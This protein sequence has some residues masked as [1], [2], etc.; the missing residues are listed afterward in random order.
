MAVEDARGLSGCRWRF[1]LRMVYKEIVGMVIPAIE[2]SV[3]NKTSVPLYPVPSSTLC[4]NLLVSYRNTDQQSSLL[5]D[6]SQTPRL[7]DFCKLDERTI[8]EFWIR[9]T[10]DRS[11]RTCFGNNGCSNTLSTS[12]RPNTIR[13]RET[14]YVM[15]RIKILIF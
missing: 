15:Y 6:R 13:P 1:K 5:C 14:A 4:L 2:E 11:A 3:A 9:S 8:I 10:T 12:S 7:Y